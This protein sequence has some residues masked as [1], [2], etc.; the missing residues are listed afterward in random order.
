MPNVKYSIDISRNHYKFALTHCR[1]LRYLQGNQLTGS[2]PPEFGKLAQL[3]YLYAQNRIVFFENIVAIFKWFLLIR[4]LFSNQ[5]NGTIPP[6]LGNL[7]K[8]TALYPQHCI[9]HLDNYKYLLN[10][11]RS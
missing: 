5:L 6:Q 3:T 2:I 9:I 1:S 4:D 10:K 8:L 7:T 11:F